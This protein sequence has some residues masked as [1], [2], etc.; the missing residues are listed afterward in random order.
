MAVPN[1]VLKGICSIL[2][3]LFS[4]ESVL[5][6]RCGLPDRKSW[7][8]LYI[9]NGCDGERRE[10]KDVTVAIFSPPCN[11]KAIQELKKFTGQN[12]SPV[13][14]KCSGIETCSL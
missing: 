9:G 5:G 6:S 14:P 8:S 2:R 1:A 11:S 4:V 10:G 7:P 3:L 12:W 13:Y